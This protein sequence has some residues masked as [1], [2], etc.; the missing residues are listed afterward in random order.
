MNTN[1]NM[2]TNPITHAGVDRCWKVC[3]CSKCGI[4]AQCIPIFDFYGDDNK[5]EPLI[6]ENC[7]RKGL[8]EKGITP[9]W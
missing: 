4:I 8:K 3:K 1:P 6:C 7:F 9:T 2:N 5:K